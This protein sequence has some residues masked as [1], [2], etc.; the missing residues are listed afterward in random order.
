MLFLSPGIVYWVETLLYWCDSKAVF[1]TDV[2]TV[3]A[4]SF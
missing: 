3:Y 2:S 4:N 1:I